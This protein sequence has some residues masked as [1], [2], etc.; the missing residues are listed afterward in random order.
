MFS[1]QI[2]DSIHRWSSLICTISLLILCLSGL[3]LIFHEEIKSLTENH[4]STTGAGIASSPRGIDATIKAA[5]ADHPNQVIQ[6]IAFDDGQTV[7]AN[8]ATGP[9]TNA[10]PSKTQYTYYNTH[11]AQK[12][13]IPLVTNRVMWFLLQLHKD[14]FLGLNGTLFIGG[15]GLCFLVSLISGIVL[16]APFM[17]KLGFGEIRTKSTKKLKWLDRHNLLGIVT[18]TWAFVV[19]LTGIINTLSTPIASLWQSGQLA[20]M[21]S[22]YKDLPLVTK[23]TSVDEAIIVAQSAAPNMEPFIIAYPGTPFS[24]KHH[25]AIF[26]QGKTPI[27]SRLLTPALIDAKT[28]E[29]T[30]MR[31][32]PW[33]VSTMFISQPLHFGDYGGLPLKII[34]AVFDVITIIILISG[35]YLWLSRWKK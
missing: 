26:M 6:Y 30:A 27:T 24:S 10:D 17:R 9:A 13:D 11:T 21:T 4:P 33:Y 32:M 1:L 2:W 5:L 31:A 8:I 23:F 3:P 25:Y 15:M 35:V 18:L 16:Y 12:A 28:G 19:C 22:P 34:W 20:E 14:L 29:L 7:I